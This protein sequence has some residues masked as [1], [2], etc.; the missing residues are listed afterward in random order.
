MRFR[1]CAAIAVALALPIAVPSLL[2]APAQAA[3]AQAAQAAQGQA[4]Q[5][6]TAPAQNAPGTAT[7]N[8]AVPKTMA[9]SPLSKIP[10]EVHPFPLADNGS[11]LDFM[12]RITA[13]SGRRCIKQEQYGWEFTH[14]DQLAVD[15]VF[16]G[17]MDAAAKGGYQLT[18]LKPQTITDSETAAYYAVKDKLRL[19]MVWVPLQ[20]SVLL[21][22]CQAEAGKPV[23]Q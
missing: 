3:Q 20:D 8:P 6:Q 22:M 21:M 5:P 11:Y 9:V 13:E 18:K 16:Q 2:G 19:L 17:T 4:A 14:N 10:F 12:N 1:S 23:K 7:P 15:K